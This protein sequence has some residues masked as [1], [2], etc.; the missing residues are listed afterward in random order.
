ML[1]ALSSCGMAL[2]TAVD[3]AQGGTSDTLTLFI[4]P[5][6]SLN[7]YNSI[8]IVP[9]IS[10]IGTQISPE[11]LNDLNDKIV[12][13]LFDNGVKQIKGGEL[14]ISG[15]VLHLP[16]DTLSKQIIV[17]VKFHDSATNQSI[18]IVNLLV[19]PTAF[20]ALAQAWAPQ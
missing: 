3:R 8:E 4:G 13:N 1:L 18:G 11:L 6:Q 12:T 7:A 5:V 20:V 16:D 14:R 10:A 2:K 9:F 17:Q 15:S 19:R